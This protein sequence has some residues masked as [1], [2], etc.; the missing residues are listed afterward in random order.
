MQ[1]VSSNNGHNWEDSDIYCQNMF[2]THLASFHSLT[3][4]DDAI[5]DGSKCAC[6]CNKQCQK[7]DWNLNHRYHCIGK[8]LS[9]LTMQE[10]GVVQ[11]IRLINHFLG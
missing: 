4:N 8:H 9:H 6:Y 5:G 10:N 7:R 11:P 1:R 3:Q 2:G